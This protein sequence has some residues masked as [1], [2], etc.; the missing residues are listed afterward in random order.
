MISEPVIKLLVSL[1]FSLATNNLI[2]LHLEPP[3]KTFV[4][5]NT[6]ILILA[7]GILIFFS[8]AS[9]LEFIEDNIVTVDSKNKAVIITGNFFHL[10]YYLHY[11]GI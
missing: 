5:A 6:L 9:Y 7:L 8:V 3:K 4:S 1:L 2:I 11:N 10:L